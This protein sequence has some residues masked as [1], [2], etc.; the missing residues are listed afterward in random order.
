MPFEHANLSLV[1]CG[2]EVRLTS[3]GYSNEKAD[4]ELGDSFVRE[5]LKA[6]N[7]VSWSWCGRYRCFISET[8]N[9]CIFSGSYDD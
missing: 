4:L 3:V 1:Q 9:A 7:N 2:A 5:V 6:N 8:F